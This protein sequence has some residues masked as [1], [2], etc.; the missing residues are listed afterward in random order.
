MKK[1]KELSMY[2]K[3]WRD[4]RKEQTKN[5]AELILH[6]ELCMIA[7]E[8]AKKFSSVHMWVEKGRF[9]T[10]RF[11]PFIWDHI[12]LHLYLA[13][14]DTATS[15][16]PIIDSMIADSRLDLRETPPKEL[17]DTQTASWEFVP[18]GSKTYKPYLQA[19]VEYER[20][21]SCKLVPT[22]RFS[23]RREI[24]KMVCNGDS[25]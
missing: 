7:E 8:Y 16:H 18:K 13:E 10:V 22:G 3:I 6:A 12:R 20:S 2:E 1:T 4:L 24:M 25:I 11:D 5:R 9:S 17:I 15:A 21:E 14:E 23:E 19:I